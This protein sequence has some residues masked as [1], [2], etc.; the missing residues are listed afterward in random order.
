MTPK[1]SY[2]AGQIAAVGASIV[3]NSSSSVVMG[4]PSTIGGGKPAY[5]RVSVTSV[6]ASANVA[7]G[8]VRLS[9]T[10]TSATATTADTVV[11]ANESLWL[12][13]LGMS[14][15]AALG[16]PLLARVQ[17]SPLEEGV[18]IPSAGLTPGLG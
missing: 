18:I 15:I 6:A 14:A 13:T 4:L 5:V 7:F 12:A 16:G 8:F 9:P 1:T 3:M 2:P 10:A 17:V 11:T